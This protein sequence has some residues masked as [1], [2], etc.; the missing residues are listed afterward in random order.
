MERLELSFPGITAMIFQLLLSISEPPLEPHN[1]LFKA[2]GPEQNSDTRGDRRGRGPK[3][4]V[5]Y[6]ACALPPVQG[7]VFKET[8]GLVIV[9]GPWPCGLLVRWPVRSVRARAAEKAGE[10]QRGG[11]RCAVWGGP[12][13]SAA[14]LEW[15]WL[16]PRPPLSLGA[17][18]P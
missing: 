5:G 4:Q 7:P 9:Q 15:P 11:P 17:H 10:G 13:P 12:G 6:C 18:P 16:L 14:W 1:T 2:S 8:G 3:A